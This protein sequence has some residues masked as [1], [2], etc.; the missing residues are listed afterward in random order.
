MLNRTAACCLAACAVASPTLAGDLN[1]PAGPIAATGR[2]GPR[3]EINQAN[4]P[5]DANSVFKIT[6]PGSYYLSGNIVGPAGFNGIEVTSNDVVIDLMGF[7]LDGA[8]G[9]LTGIVTTSLRQNLVV[10]NGTIRDWDIN[11]IH[12]D[13]FSNGFLIEDIIFREIGQNGVLVAFAGIIRNCSFTSCP[14]GINSNCCVLVHNCRFGQASVVGV[15]GSQNVTVLDGVF[16][17]CL[18]G[19]KMTSEGIVSRC[20]IVFARPAGNGIEVNKECYIYN[21]VIDSSNSG[22][23]ILVTGND[24]RIE[25][26]SVGGMGTGYSVSG[27]GNLI[28]RNSASLGVASFNIAGGNLF[29]P[30]VTSANIAVSTNPHSNYRQ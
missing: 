27:T 7:N 28:I 8:A 18:G 19:V 1:P 20:T 11:G 9:S 16:N 22:N 29:G 2:F 14:T 17:N 26:N 30:I 24:N 21:N 4:T 5:G 12:M 23:G 3:I 15:I 10:R 6:R 25:G 13:L